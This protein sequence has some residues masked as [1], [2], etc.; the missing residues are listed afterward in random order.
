MDNGTPIRTKMSTKWASLPSKFLKQSIKMYMKESRCRLKH[1][2]GRGGE[3][4]FQKF[5]ELVVEYLTEGLIRP[6]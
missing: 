1:G 3:Y 4:A 6:I 2:V 5:I